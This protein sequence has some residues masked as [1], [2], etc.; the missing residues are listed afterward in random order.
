MPTALFFE[1]RPEEVE[2]FTR[3]LVDCGLDVYFFKE[4]IGP[5]ITVDISRAEILLEDLL[6]ISDIVTLHVPLTPATYHLINW[7]RLQLMKRGALLINTSRGAVVDTK[8]LIRALD[9]GIIAGAG[10]DVIEGEELIQEEW[11]LLHM[12]EAEEKLKTVLRAH[13]LLR[14][15]NV[16]V[17][18][19]YWFLQPRGS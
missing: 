10:L 11:A 12:P 17:T 16:V 1:V 6:R 18:P 9:E 2:Y 13:L 19:T 14:R 15:E 4:P 7:H 8:A 3:E 5:N